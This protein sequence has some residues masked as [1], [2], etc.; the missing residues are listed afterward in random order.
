MRRAAYIVHS[1]EGG[2]FNFGEKDFNPFCVALVPTRPTMSA[3][4]DRS[5][6]EC[7]GVGDRGDRGKNEYFSYP[8][9]GVI[10]RESA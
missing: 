8:A 1:P 5:P 6:R 9:P 4:V 10:V 7:S 2:G 3:S